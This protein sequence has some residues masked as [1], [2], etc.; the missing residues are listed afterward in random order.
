MNQKLLF[1]ASKDGTKQR[2]TGIH[3]LPFD[4]DQ[5][6]PQATIDANILVDDIAVPENNGK[7]AIRY[8]NPQTK[9]QTFEYIDPPLTIKDQ[10]IQLQDAQKTPDDKYKELDL[11][12]AALADVQNAKVAQLKYLCEEAI[13]AGF[14]SASTGHVFGLDLKDQANFEQ[15]RSDFIDDATATSVDW[16]TKDAGVVTL[17]KDEFMTVRQEGKQFKWDN[18][19]RVRDLIGQ[20]MASTTNDAVDAIKW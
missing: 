8:V 5:G 18:I 2:V 6:L 7:I 3:Y 19:N 16:G 17:T 14:T 13:Y 9:E 11:T 4:K 15:Q 1:V 20:V 12:T 10:L